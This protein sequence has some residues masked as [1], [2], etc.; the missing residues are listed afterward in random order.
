MTELS[1]DLQIPTFVLW[2]IGAGVWL[3]AVTA[4][5]QSLEAIIALR[6]ERAEHRRRARERRLGG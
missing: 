1:F 6:R 2:I 4:I 5:P 3:W